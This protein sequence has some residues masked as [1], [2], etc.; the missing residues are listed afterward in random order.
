MHKREKPL[1]FLRR[2]KKF[3]RNTAGTHRPDHRS[4]FERRLVVLKR[5]LKIKDIVHMHRSLALNDAPAHRNVQDGSFAPDFAARE[6]Q[7]QAHGNTQMFS[8]IEHLRR[9]TAPQSESL[10]TEAT[11]LTMERGNTSK[12]L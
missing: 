11:R 12:R 7:K 3:E 9:I 6:G 10:E 4:H 1:V 5:D 8:P 2:P